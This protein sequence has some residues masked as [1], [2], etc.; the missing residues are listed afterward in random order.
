MSNAPE[1][2]IEE[3]YKARRA[4]RPEEARQLFREAVE[5]C[6]AAGNP[7]PL[8]RALKGLGQMERDLKNNLEALRHYR[9]AAEIDRGLPDPLRFAHTI[10]HVAD[11]LRNERDFDPA[12][13]C[14]EEALSV[15][16]T[17]KEAPDLDLANAIRGFAVL[18]TATGERE[19]AIALWREAGNLY[20]AVNV[21]P[22]VAESEQQ[23]EM[24]SASQ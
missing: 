23:I 5:L 16:R 12:R 10:R 18:K 1:A 19:E 17:H 15:Y 11:I 8:S 22:G 21:Q 13:V 9:E 7:E 24:L 4:G 2:L 20:R 6:R 3:G 14:Y